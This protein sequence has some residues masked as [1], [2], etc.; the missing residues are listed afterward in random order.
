MDVGYT[1]TV[2]TAGIEPATFRFSN[3]CCFHLSYVGVRR[4]SQAALPFSPAGV[5]VPY[6]A[7]A[8]NM[9]GGSRAHWRNRTSDLIFIRDVL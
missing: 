7:A 2:P 3:G 8:L 1:I 5:Y 6:L 9:F 4:S